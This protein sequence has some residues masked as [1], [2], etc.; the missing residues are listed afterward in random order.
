MT[1]TILSIIAIL[2]IIYYL[3]RPEN[4]DQENKEVKKF[5]DGLLQDSND[6]SLNKK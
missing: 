3:A 2:L 6:I 4:L 5:G 1:L